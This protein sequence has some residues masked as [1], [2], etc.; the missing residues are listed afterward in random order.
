MGDGDTNVNNT[1]SG[2][3]TFDSVFVSGHICPPPIRQQAPFIPDCLGGSI[4]VRFVKGEEPIRLSFGYDSYHPENTGGPVHNVSVGIGSELLTGKPKSWVRRS[5]VA[6]LNPTLIVLPEGEVDFS[7]NIQTQDGLV[8]SKVP[9]VAGVN[10]FVGQTAALAGDSPYQLLFGV[11]FSFPNSK[12]T[13]KEQPLGKWSYA[14]ARIV[15][16]YRLG[17]ISQDAW[18]IPRL[19]EDGFGY[20]LDGLNAAA[21]D[22]PTTLAVLSAFDETDPKLRPW[23]AGGMTAAGGIL[24][25]RG[26]SQKKSSLY[27]VGDLV[28]V[29]GAAGL[30]SVFWP[31]RNRNKWARTLFRSAV[32][33]I[34]GGTG[35]LLMTDEETRPFGMA[36][37]GPTSGVLVFD[38]SEHLELK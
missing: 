30:A 38:L 24:M 13:S 34:N 33:T 28:A 11:E 1:T 16:K 27:G 10:L 8:A 9:G 14:A 18:N 29:N 4:G 25:G 21:N 19:A 22:I 26:W 12:Y 5:H 7:A 36:M 32:A 3:K 37:M 17:Q 15:P 23:I 2:S 31:D 35:G 20:Q 6:S